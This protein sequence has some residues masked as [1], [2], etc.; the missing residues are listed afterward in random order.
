VKEVEGDRFDTSGWGVLFGVAL[1]KGGKA[2]IKLAKA[3]Q[4]WIDE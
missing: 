3:V 1:V 4:A 2:D